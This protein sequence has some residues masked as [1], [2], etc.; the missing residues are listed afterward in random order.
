MGATV[1]IPRVV[2]SKLWPHQVDALDM[3]KGY[4][5]ARAPG[6]GLVR[7]PTGSGKT[8]IIACLAQYHS[9]GGNILVVAP[10]KQLVAQTVAE[11][12]A[13]F[14]RKL[15]VPAPGTRECVRLTPAD[16]PVLLK[17]G[18]FEKSVIVTTFSSLQQLAANDPTTYQKLASKCEVAL[19]DEGHREPAP[20]WAAA[21]RGLGVP[22]VLF[23]ATPYRN[24][25]LEFR[26]DAAHVFRLTLT[27]ATRDRFIRSVVFEEHDNLVSAAK[28][29]KALIVAVDARP[30]NPG[31]RVIVRCETEADVR[32]LLKLFLAAGRTAVGIHENFKT[33]PAKGVFGSVPAPTT[34]P[35]QFWIH[36]NKLIEGI[37]DPA[38]SVLAFYG[39][40]GN[41]RGF[42]QQVGRVLRNPQ[43]KRGQT[44]LVFGRTKDRLRETWA[45]FVEY[46]KRLED[47]QAEEVGAVEVVQRVIEAT[48]RL[49]Y[50]DGQFRGP[51][52]PKTSNAYKSLAFRRSIGLFTIAPTFDLD[53]LLDACRH[54]LPKADAIL[55]GEYTPDP[56]VRVVTHVQ[57]APT[58][59]LRGATFLDMRF[60][61][62]FARV[63]K[64]R[65]FFY[66]TNGLLPKYLG[67][68]AERVTIAELEGLLG[69]GNT[70]L[71]AVSLLNL[72]LGMYSVRRRT[73]SARSV[74]ATAPALSDH[75]HFCSTAAGITDSASGRVRRYV[76]LSRGRVSDQAADGIELDDFLKWQDELESKLGSGAHD[77]FGRFAVREKS[78]KDPT[79]KN[80]LLD[81][82]EALDDFQVPVGS[83]TL[84]L[85]K[86]V[87]DRCWDVDT[88]GKF[89][90]ELLDGSKVDAKISFDTPRRR[91]R[92]D[93]PGLQQI[94]LEAAVAG[95]RRRTLTAFLNHEQAFRV[96]T[97]DGAVYARGNYYRPR[98]PLWGPASGADRIALESVL[99]ADSR[100]LSITSEKGS[101]GS[102]GAAGWANDSLFGYVDARNGLLKNEKV[103]LLICDDLGN[104]LA[105]FI[106]VT[107]APSVILIHAKH[108]KKSSKI[109]AS[110]FHDVC[111]QATKNLGLLAPQSG[112]PPKNVA[113]W[114]TAWKHK[115]YGTVSKRL[116][117]GA[118]PPADVWKRVSTIL[119]DP[120]A[121]R[122][123]WILMGD[124]LSRTA[125]EI[126]RKKLKP[127]PRAVQ[128]F[129]LLQSTWSSV[130]AV[131][132]KLKVICRP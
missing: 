9:G 120:S 79:P 15:K 74:E 64:Q 57:C 115:D 80:V 86:A 101:L 6:G 114:G 14:W 94:A 38:F 121:S 92:I 3:V 4:L 100:L 71:T 28:F 35:E 25:H 19:V 11:V 105:D 85:G 81:V 44:A 51:A 108:P 36:Q 125:F 75:F 53:A 62:T 66:D 119:R 31:P 48:R 84:P 118:L 55:L 30:A 102:A 47:P 37:D 132:A 124:G 98:R 69:V 12:G 61:Y 29:V 128:F 58:R 32:E 34:R 8:G 50:L 17:D 116:R 107:S 43:R 72:D 56:S 60:G 97:A 27:E 129:Y 23:T 40:L 42:V 99:H 41:E 2:L 49:N 1:S 83:E 122:E 46:E 89:S 127:A 65:L 117:R 131:G 13:D 82:E 93:S 45:R 130:S 77:V 123:V 39:K 110:A 68:H 76:G 63:V 90:V 54:E 103:D 104:E 20:R 18:K 87:E 73:M 59:L 111:G 33:N 10:W 95:R 21:V 88:D 113:V 24:D 78:A 52:D 22:T 109:S 96:I 106:V 112:E 67:K 16:A 5:A 91:Y 70:H 7:M 26:I 126:E